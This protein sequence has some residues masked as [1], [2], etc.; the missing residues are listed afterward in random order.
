MRTFMKGPA[1]GGKVFSV[2]LLDAA[3]GEI[4]GTFFNLAAEKFF[5]LL[6]PS[7]IFT[8]SKGRVKIADR[9]YSACNHRYELMFD[10]DAIIEPATDE[11]TI[12]ALKFSCV[13]LRTVQSRALP[14]SVDLCG[15]ITNSRQ[16]VTVK[17][18]DGQELLKRDITIADDTAFCI[19]VTLWADRAK[20][21]DSV[22]EGNPVV[23]LKGVVVK[24]WN[25]GRSGS[26]T[27]GGALVFKPNIVEAIQIQQWWSDG[28]SSQ[29]LS[30]LSQTAGGEG[31]SR[32]RNAVPTTLAGV[33]R[34]AERLT[35]QVETYSVA[36]RLAL[37]QM[38]K[39]GEAQPLQYLACQNVREGSSL[40]CN[41]R[42]D[43]SGFCSTCNL[44]GKVA[45]R[46]N[47]RCR[48]VDF[49]DQA[50]LTTFHE[51]AQRV[52]GM[53]AED[54]RALEQG[55]TSGDRD[56]TEDT[57]ER[58]EAAI[59]ARYF[60]KP[61]SLIVRA[62]LDT[63]NGEPRSNITVVEARPVN[64]G[65]HGRFLLKEIKEILAN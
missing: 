61:M 11:G 2:D 54:V 21:E 26:L 52:L 4:R 38:R 23:A 33:R 13:G 42:V 41:R 64:R 28:G 51:A 53:T 32:A 9:R 1:G 7:Q 14:C 6:K 29:T 43:A 36:A 39:Q 25:G 12:E 47:I 31:S 19:T 48:F 10:A 5:D 22:F 58:L 59:Q 16:L 49:E 62:K 45:P 35:D 63:Y 20:Q 34:A 50:W 17:S 56:R 37:V 40:A 30:D 24:E 8:F 15:V 44:A 55:A 18:K 60:A 46:L 27:A 57:R 3:G 65:E